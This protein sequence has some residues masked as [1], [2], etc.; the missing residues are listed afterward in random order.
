[1]SPPRGPLSRWR[2]LPRVSRSLD[3]KI[4]RSASQIGTPE[5]QDETRRRHYKRRKQELKNQYAD[6]SV[7][8]SLT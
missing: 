8:Q 7:T 1:M 2:L 3:G 4:P 5:D 6:V